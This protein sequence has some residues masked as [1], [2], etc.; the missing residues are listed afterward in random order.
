MVPIEGSL[1]DLSETYIFYSFSSTKYIVISKVPFI[2]DQN[3][4][5]WIKDINYNKNK[6]YFFHWFSM[7]T[8]FVEN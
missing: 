5:N 3:Y 8:C 4:N 2:N 6:Q 1:K 7:V